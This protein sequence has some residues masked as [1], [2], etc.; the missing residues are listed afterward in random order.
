MGL[1][2][3]SGLE[4]AAWISSFWTSKLSV[5][6]KKFRQKRS[7]ISQFRSGASGWTDTNNA[8]TTQQKPLSITQGTSK[9]SR[10]IG[11]FIRSSHSPKW[12]GQKLRLPLRQRYIFGSQRSGPSHPFKSR[13]PEWESER[14]KISK[15]PSFA[16]ETKSELLRPPARSFF[17]VPG[18]NGRSYWQNPGEEFLNH[19]QGHVW[20]L[21]STCWKHELIFCASSENLE[22]L[23]W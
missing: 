3:Q 6:C 19:F 9:N 22:A 23:T 20:L 16:P 11:F 18:Q 5:Q 1:L 14:T 7:F 17:E 2:W 15:L 21:A 10:C 4:G 13:G 12:K 8:H